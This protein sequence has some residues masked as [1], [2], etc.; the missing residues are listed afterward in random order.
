LPGRGIQQT[1]GTRMVAQHVLNALLER[2]VART[3]MRQERVACSRRLLHRQLKYFVQAAPLLRC[4]INPVPC[5]RIPPEDRTLETGQTYLCLPLHNSQMGGRNGFL[6][7]LAIAFS[8]TFAISLFI[9]LFPPTIWFGAPPNRCPKCQSKDIRRSMVM[10]FRDRLRML[11]QVRPFRCRGCWTRF[12][13]K[14]GK[15]VQIGEPSH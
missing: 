4:Q 6:F 10:G 12:S 3:G 11:F 5:L 14:T 1:T 8:V 15:Q 2:R 9:W 13:A 7:P